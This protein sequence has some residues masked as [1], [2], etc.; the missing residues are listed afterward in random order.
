M[1]YWLFYFAGFI[2]IASAIMAITRLNASH[3][4]IY[5]VVTLL[6]IAVIFYLLGAPFAAAL[7]IVIYAGA[8][9][10][11]FLF[12]VMMLNLGRRSVEREK[13]WLLPGI[14]VIPSIMAG[15]LFVVLGI[16]LSGTQNEAQIAGSMI[17]PQTVGR[18]LMGPYIL[19]VEL[20]GFLLLAALVG[21]YHLGRRY[22]DERREK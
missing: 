17:G 13:Q 18:A 5:L 2:A 14:W 22:L 20:A 1:A 9:V 8:I 6:S 15:A 11:L 19:G 3:A 21:A 10:V 7:Q 12:V 4:L 16:A